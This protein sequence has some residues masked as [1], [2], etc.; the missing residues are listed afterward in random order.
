MKNNIDFGEDQEA[1]LLFAFRYCLGRKTYAVSIVV[2]L[3]I[4]NWDNL[5]LIIRAMI[6]KEIIDYKKLYGDLGHNCDEIQWNR[7]LDLE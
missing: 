4:K 7:I 2:D 5:D 6:T 3:I 1:I